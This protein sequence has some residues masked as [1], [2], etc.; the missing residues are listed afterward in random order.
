[1]NTDPRKFDGLARWSG[2]SFATPIVAG[3]IATRMSRTGLSARLA[4]D[5][6]L[7]HARANAIR[8]VG[9]VL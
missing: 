7:A 1:V 5:Q 2:T 4:A 6:L 3:K 8:G 9:P